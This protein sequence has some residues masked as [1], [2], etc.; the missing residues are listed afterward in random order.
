[1]PKTNMYQSLHTTIF[2]CRGKTFEIQ[3]RTH[4]MHKIAEYGISFSLDL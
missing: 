1:M 3:I 2:G 4:E